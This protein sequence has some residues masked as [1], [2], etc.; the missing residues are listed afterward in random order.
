MCS[1]LT[2]LCLPVS[3]TPLT[4]SINRNGGEVARSKA[5][6]SHVRSSQG[7]STGIMVAAIINREVSRYQL[8]SIN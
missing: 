3:D 6:L 7:L 8:S 4:E 1:Q 2:E 5:I